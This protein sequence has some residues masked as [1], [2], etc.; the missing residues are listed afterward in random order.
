[1]SATV[2]PAFDLELPDPPDRAELLDKTDKVRRLAL[3]L[4]DPEPEPAEPPLTNCPICRADVSGC[5]LSIG[6]DGLRRWTQPV[7]HEE[8][9]DGARYLSGGLVHIEAG[10][11]CLNDAKDVAR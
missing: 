4:P 6:A 3:H 1:M 9:A 10:Q 5:A 2:A 11:R 7:K 8:K